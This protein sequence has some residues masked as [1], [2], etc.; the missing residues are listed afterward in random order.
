[1]TAGSEARVEKSQAELE[2]ARSELERMQQEAEK[3]LADLDARWDALAGS[4]TQTAIKPKKTA[5][6]VLEVSLLWKIPTTP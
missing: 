3:E 2:A 6:E 4:I 5:I 1:M